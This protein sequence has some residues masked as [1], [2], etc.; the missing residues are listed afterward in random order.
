MPFVFAIA[1]DGDELVAFWAVDD[2]PKRQRAIQRLGNIEANPSAE[3][4]VDSYEEEWT[5]LWWVRVTGR[6]RVVSSPGERT[7]ALAALI[8]KY[9]QYRAT[10]PTGPVI[11]IEIDRVTGWSATEP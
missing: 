5:E 8:D 11:A 7:K 1:R 10:P 9:P 6:A 3:F 4:V 2:K